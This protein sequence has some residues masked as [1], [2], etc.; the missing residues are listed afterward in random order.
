M[1][2]VRD[3]VSDITNHVLIL[4][5]DIFLCRIG[6]SFGKD[7]I[8]FVVAQNFQPCDLNPGESGMTR[9]FFGPFANVTALFQFAML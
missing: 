7:G 1:R 9:H 5:S 2:N 8:G 3:V 4:V 6:K